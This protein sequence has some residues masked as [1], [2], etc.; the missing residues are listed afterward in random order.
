M[1]TP[2]PITDEIVE[3]AKTIIATNEGSKTCIYCGLDDD[4]H[5][6]ICPVYIAKSAFISNYHKTDFT[7][8][9]EQTRLRRR[10]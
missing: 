5:K 10:L 3:K 7:E 8:Y 2:E 1:T 9:C 6:Y 4:E